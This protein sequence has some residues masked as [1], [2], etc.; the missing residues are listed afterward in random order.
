MCV[1]IKLPSARVCVVG[2]ARQP[3]PYGLIS[4]NEISYF[5]LLLVP[6]ILGLHHIRTLRIMESTEKRR[7]ELPNCYC[8]LASP[9]LMSFDICVGSFH[10]VPHSLSL[11]NQIVRIY[12]GS[13]TKCPKATPASGI[14]IRIQIRKK[15]YLGKLERKCCA[16][17]EMRVYEI[18]GNSYTAQPGTSSPE[19]PER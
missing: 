10:Q 19:E 18:G 7:G 6:M 4:E 2:E 12:W 11:N 5:Y 16:G 13:T 15:N 3:G 1:S 8:K 17:V 14:R 9:G